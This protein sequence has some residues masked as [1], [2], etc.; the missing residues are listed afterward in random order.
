MTS[1]TL[2]IRHAPLPA[3]A[4]RDPAGELPA[5]DVAAPA[6]P[7][8]VLR[9]DARRLDQHRRGAR[10]PGA[11]VGVP[12]A[13]PARASCRSS[14]APTWQDA[15]AFGGYA[16]MFLPWFVDRADAVHL[17]HAAR[18]SVHVPRASPRPCGGL[19]PRSGGSA[20]AVVRGARG[21]RRGVAFMPV[22]IGWSVPSCVDRRARW[23]PAGRSEP[24]PRTKKGRSEDRPFRSRAC[25]SDLGPAGRRV[26][27]AVIA[28]HRC[29]SPQAVLAV[30][31]PDGR[32]V[33]DPVAGTRRRHAS[34]RPRACAAERS[35]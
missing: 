12:R 23:S 31:R 21:P 16:A 8:P 11:V 19:P 24:R 2:Q 14:A 17:V 1:S 6:A 3:G 34:G 18:R 4:P 27:A 35:R 13:A 32:V 5:V 25:V 10:E 15:V 7:R 9:R 22:W 28:A 33:G 20:P 30:L 29:R 26:C